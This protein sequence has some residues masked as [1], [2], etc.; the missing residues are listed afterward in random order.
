M[1]NI[2]GEYTLA[3]VAAQI[4]VSPA[5]INKIRSSTG[6]G[7]DLGIQG[8]KSNF[9]DK[10]LAELKRTKSLRLLEL[11]YDDLKQVYATE[12]ELLKFFFYTEGKN[13]QA[14]CL[15]VHTDKILIDEK[16]LAKNE[17]LREAWMDYCEIFHKVYNKVQYMMAEIEKIGAEMKHDL[18]EYEQLK[19]RLVKK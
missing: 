15:L 1:S 6:I 8:K 16:V 12:N 5:W 13:N 17:S 14:L 19:K 2:H 4:G 10:D 11:D 3:E 7:G 18:S 9:T